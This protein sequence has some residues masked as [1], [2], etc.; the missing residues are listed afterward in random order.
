M[1]ACVLVCVGTC[2]RTCVCVCVCVC[3]ERETVDVMTS[4]LSRYHYHG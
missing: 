4:V 2:V 1:H 3:G